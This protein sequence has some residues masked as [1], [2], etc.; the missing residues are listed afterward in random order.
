M[1]PLLQWVHI[2]AVHH[3]LLGFILQTTCFMPRF[4]LVGLSQMA[5]SFA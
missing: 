2:K 5:L 1:I 4:L 3:V